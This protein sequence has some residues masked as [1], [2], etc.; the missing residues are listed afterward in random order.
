MRT[1]A[2]LDCLDFF[3]V[4]LHIYSQAHHRL[5]VLE[6]W[7][8]CTLREEPALCSHL[9]DASRITRMVSDI[10]GRGD[11]FSPACRSRIVSYIYF[12]ES[13]ISFCLSE[14]KNKKGEL[15]CIPWMRNCILSCLGGLQQYWAF[16]K[17]FD[18]GAPRFEFWHKFF[19][20]DIITESFYQSIVTENWLLSLTFDG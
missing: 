19:P 15:F 17:S 1:R 10:V 20:H 4:L 6:C 8:D 7:F 3:Y 11:H 16:M 14:C 12:F 5:V 18:I 9:H 13:Q 2:P